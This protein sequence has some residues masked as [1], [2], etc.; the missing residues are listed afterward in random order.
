[1]NEHIDG[2]YR[3]VRYETPV[4]S[5]T[6]RHTYTPNG[7]TWF[8]TEH[9]VKTEED[10]KTLT[11]LY[12]DVALVPDMELF[13]SDY[14]EL[15][16]GGL[17]L[18]VMGTDMKTPFQ[19]LIE[20]MAGTVQLAY[21]LADYPQTVEAC[22]AVMNEKAVE[23]CRISAQSPAEALLFYEDSSTTNIS[24]AQFVKYTAPVV[25]RWSAICHDAGKLLIHH[26]CGHLRALLG[27]MAETGIDAVES[28][29]PPPTGNIELWEAKATLPD[30]V[31]LIGGIEPTVF[32]YSAMAELERH[33]RRLIEKVGRRRFVLSNSDS[34]PPGVTL[35]KFH[36]V[37][38]IVR[39]SI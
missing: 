13:C 14:Q 34:C 5:L 20:H 23:S 4:G 9:P 18:P 36:L 26:A 29:S 28:I 21:A 3:V 7:N 24:P 22:L 30:T 8:L 25:S 31:A 12:E 39:D 27:H 2:N 19:L 35:E 6:S 32:L 10:F 11:F 16:D 38:R 33:V 15:G 1:V 37:S 17:Y